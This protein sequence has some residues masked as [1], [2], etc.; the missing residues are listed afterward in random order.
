MRMA[1][2]HFAGPMMDACRDFEGNE[3]VTT[4]LT[5]EGNWCSV[6]VWKCRAHMEVFKKSHLHKIAMRISSDWI[7]DFQF[8]TE[9]MERT[10]DDVTKPEIVEKLKNAKL[11]SKLSAH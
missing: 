3:G 9:K 4:F 1:C 5:E 7:Q 2:R 11:A 6:S 10:F 8:I